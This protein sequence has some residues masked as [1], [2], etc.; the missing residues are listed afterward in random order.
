MKCPLL[1]ADK[2]N[3]G[4]F[5]NYLILLWLCDIKTKWKFNIS[6][7][8]FC[9]SS[10]SFKNQFSSVLVQTTTIEHHR[11]GDLNNSHLFLT[12]LGAGSPRSGASMVGFSVRALFLGA[13]FLVYRWPYFPCLR[14]KVLASSFPLS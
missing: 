11:L 3:N 13:H 9:F 8:P 4:C 6:P 12:G 7:Y 1:Y 5:I 2:K 14:E 10:D